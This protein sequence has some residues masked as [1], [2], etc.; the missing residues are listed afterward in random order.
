MARSEQG[1]EEAARFIAQALPGPAFGVDALRHHR[2]EQGTEGL[3]P[4]TLLFEEGRRRLALDGHHGNALGLLRD[5]QR[6]QPSGT[7]AL[8]QRGMRPEAVR[9]VVLRCRRFHGLREI[10]GF[11]HGG[12]IGMHQRRRL[13]ECR[14]F[15][16]GCQPDFA[17]AQQADRYPRTAEASAQLVAQVEQGLLETLVAQCDG[18]RL[19][20]AQRTH[21]RGQRRIMFAPSEQIAEPGA[22]PV[23][24]A[25]QERQGFVVCAQLQHH[26]AGDAVMHRQRRRHMPQT[27]GFRAG[28]HHHASVGQ[29]ALHGFAHA[30]HIA[31]GLRKHGDRHEVLAVRR[32]HQDR[33]LHDRCKLVAQYGQPGIAELRRRARGNEARPA[34]YR[35]GH[36]CGGI[37][38]DGQGVHRGDC[39]GWSEAVVSMPVGAKRSSSS[40][41]S[42]MLRSPRVVRSLI[43]A[44]SCW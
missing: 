6:K 27:G 43:Y 32:F 22:T 11:V 4:F 33:R 44:V 15:R 38:R 28:L 19:Q 30:R 13:F 3:K 31:V 18:H 36:R 35:Q 23:Q 42:V 24:F 5:G 14:R 7:G 29:R 37:G 41:I 26:G 20:Y 17:M 2:C 8:Q 9:R 12:G 21:A 25:Q 39:S 16:Q 34:V 40:S 10:A 1:A